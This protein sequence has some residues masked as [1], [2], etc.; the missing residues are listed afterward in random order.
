VIELEL[1]SVK[2]EV[3]EFA[4][5]AWA[6]RAMTEYRSLQIMTR[7]VSELAAAG[8]ALET[9]TWAAELITDELRHAALCREVCRALGTAPRMPEPL[10]LPDPPSFL[11]LPANQRAVMTAVTMLLVSESLSV[12]VIE[13][14]RVRCEN[15]PIRAVLDALVGDEAEHEQH[16]LDF[17]RGSL[18]R[19]PPAALPGWRDIAQKAL[20]PRLSQQRAIVASLPTAK[21][22]RDAWPEPELVALGLMGPERQAIVYVDAY[23]RVLAPRLRDVGLLV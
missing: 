4:R 6:E 10:A 19:S 12:A 9:Q 7:F 21:Q 22:T 15:P 16:G 23:E 2:P 5:R 11:A 8:V 18:A 1:R 3:L 20:E 14:L 17:V 13:D